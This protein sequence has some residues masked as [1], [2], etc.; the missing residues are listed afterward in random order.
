MLGVVEKYHDRIDNEATDREDSELEDDHP[1]VKQSTAKKTTNSKPRRGL[2]D[3]PNELGEDDLMSLMLEQENQY[4]LNERI[5]QIADGLRQ[6]FYQKQ[7]RIT[8]ARC[9]KCVQ[10]PRKK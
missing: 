2:D 9:S 5:F 10:F 4:P 1:L 8:D 3:G 7:N 6:I